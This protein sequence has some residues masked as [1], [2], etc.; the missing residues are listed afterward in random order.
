MSIVRAIAHAHDGEAVAA[1]RAGGGAIVLIALPTGMP[2]P[3]VL[4]PH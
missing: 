1:N 3:A 2:A 4:H